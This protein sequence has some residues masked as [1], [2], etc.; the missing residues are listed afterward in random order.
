MQ[1]THKPHTEATNSKS[2]CTEEG[3]RMHKIEPLKM[4]TI[5]KLTTVSTRRR[6]CCNMFWP[7]VYMNQNFVQSNGTAWM[8]HCS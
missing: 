5:R 4:P 2:R 3:A 8:L 6:I 1:S 7:T